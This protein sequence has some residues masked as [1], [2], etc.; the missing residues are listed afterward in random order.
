MSVPVFSC[1]THFQ[2]GAYRKAQRRTE[3]LSADQCGVIEGS[4]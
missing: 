3:R 1:A 4:N 2:V